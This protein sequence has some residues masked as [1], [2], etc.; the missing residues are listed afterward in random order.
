MFDIDWSAYAGLLVAALLGL[1]V[2]VLVSMR[3]RT[4]APPHIVHRRVRCPQHGRTA[5]VE[6]TERVQ[7]GVALRSVRHC[8]LR[9]EG[10]QC[11][12][13]CAWE[14]SLEGP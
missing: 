7:T 6:F 11:G 12:E 3:D 2:A 9:R 1:C 8:P 10:E 4:H 5:M 13:G 14:H